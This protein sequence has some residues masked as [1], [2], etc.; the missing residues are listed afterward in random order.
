[1]KPDLNLFSNE[2][3]LDPDVNEGKYNKDLG[4]FM[5]IP[6]NFYHRTIHEMAFYQKQFAFLFYVIQ[7]LFI[8]TCAVEKS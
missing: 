4:E 3:N 1:M 6:T 5:K 8:K 7:K 2:D